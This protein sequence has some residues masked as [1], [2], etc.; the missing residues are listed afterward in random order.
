MVKGHFIYE[1]LIISQH[2]S[3]GSVFDKLIKQI[4]PKRILEIGT[5][6]GGL[7]LMLKDLLNDNGL[8]NSI[9]RTYDILEQTNLKNKNVDG[10]EIITKSPFNY[11]YSDLEYPDEIKEFVQSEGTT[12]VLCDG[13]FKINEFILISKFLKVNDVIMAHDYAHDSDVF[14]KEIE[15]KIWNWH[16]IQYSDISN[17]CEINNLESYMLD[18]FKQVVWVCKM[19]TK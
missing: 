10:I 5:A 9:I 18:E 4:K 8:N 13:G 2:E 1:N 14:K 12:L 6:D 15:N 11:P 16:E 7:T 3:V 19:K 17:A